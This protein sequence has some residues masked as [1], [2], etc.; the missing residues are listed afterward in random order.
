MEVSPPNNFEI[1]YIKK[2]LVYAANFTGMLE[3]YN[4]D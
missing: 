4:G 3:V 2:I 1:C